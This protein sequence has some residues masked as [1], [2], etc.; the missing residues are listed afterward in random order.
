MPH[1]GI[2]FRGNGGI[3][4]FD[5]NIDVT[6][7]YGSWGSSSNNGTLKPFSVVVTDP[8]DNNPFDGVGQTNIDVYANNSLIY[9]YVKGNGGYSDNY[10]NFGGLS[11]VGVDNLAIEKAGETAVTEGGATDTYSIVLNRPPTA[12]VVITLNGGTQ[13][14]TNVSTLTFTP[15]N[16]NIAQNVTVS[17]IND[18]IG[19]GQHQGIITATVSSSD[20]NYNNLAVPAVPVS[21][22]DNDLI[23]TGIRNYIAQTGTANP[24]NNVDAGSFSKPILADIDGDRDLDL[25]VGNSDGTLKYYKNI[26]SVTTP[27][28]AEQTGTANPFNGV[29][30]GDFSSPVFSD[31]DGDGD[32]DLIV[33][34]G[35]GTL[36]YYRNTGSATNPI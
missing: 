36:R 11:V 17:A 7:F 8:T 35:D 24:L 28:Y 16:W 12:N 22:T 25:V 34:A 27:S 18:S 26:G 1:F 33:G 20:P 6:G 14:S 15:S 13:L 19:E 5:G 2:L 21:I 29:N 30:V 10:V 31:L 9:S 23:T 32:R 3:Q 4:A